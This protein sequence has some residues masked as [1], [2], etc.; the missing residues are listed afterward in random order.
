MGEPA[1]DDAKGQRNASNGRQSRVGRTVN[2]RF[3]YRI[4]CNSRS[5]SSSIGCFL[6]GRSRA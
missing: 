3:P 6:K 2:M 1:D 4:S 5:I